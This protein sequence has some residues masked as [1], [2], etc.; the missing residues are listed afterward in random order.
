MTVVSAG[1][2]A[3]TIIKSVAHTP[4]ASPTTTTITI[5]DDETLGYSIAAI[6]SGTSINFRPYYRGISA[7]KPPI[8]ANNNYSR[9]HT[10]LRGGIFS[11][12]P[13]PAP[14]TGLVQPFVFTGAAPQR[15]LTYSEYCF[16]R[17]EAALRGAP[18]SAQQFFTDGIT[19]CMDEVGVLPADRNTYLATYGTLSGTTAQQIQQVIEEKYISNFGVSIEPWVDWRRTGFPA[20]SIP[21]NAINGV[22]AVPR[23]L[24]YPQSEIDLNPNNPGQKSS[25]LQD[26]VFWDN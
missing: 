1:I 15:L 11:G 12:T 6:S 7:A 8:N 20:I 10:F 16:I 13:A 18:G 22:T 2:P 3:F 4:A 19:A 5:N 9:I 17:A 14:Y 24:F 21:T 26:R 23:T 25:S